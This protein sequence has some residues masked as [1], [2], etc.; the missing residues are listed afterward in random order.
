MGCPA[1]FLARQVEHA[2]PEEDNQAELQ[3][4]E[5]GRGGLSRGLEPSAELSSLTVLRD[6]FF[7]VDNPIFHSNA[8]CAVALSPDG[9][10]LSSGGNDM[11]VSGKWGAGS[12]AV[13]FCTLWPAHFHHGTAEEGALYLSFMQAPNRK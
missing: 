7:A 12:Q 2:P 10:R 6:P 5:A 3:G 9:T 1:T 11:Q 4:Q 13:P 8:V